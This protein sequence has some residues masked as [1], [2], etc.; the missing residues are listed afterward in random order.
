MSLFNNPMINA[1]KESMS[2]KDLEKY[3][4]L[5]ESMYANIDF[6]KAAVNNIPP[7]ME[8]FLVYISSAI[9]SGL[10]PSMLSHD[11]KKFMNEIVGEK[12]YEN[13][14]YVKEDLENIVTIKFE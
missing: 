14:G 5:G 2:E 7:D 11:E 8:D 10:H 9:K 13:Y 3:R 4:K 1:A 12:W 6:E